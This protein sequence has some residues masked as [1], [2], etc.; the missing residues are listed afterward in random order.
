[1]DT[2]DKLKS[3]LNFSGVSSSIQDNLNSIDT[4]ALAKG[5]SSVSKGFSTLEIMAIAAIAN[6]TSRVVDLGIQMAKSLS[7]DQIA[8]G[9]GQFKEYAVSEATL[10]A[11]GIDQ[12]DVTQT[13]E[14]STLVC[15]RN[16]I[17][18]C[19]YVKQHV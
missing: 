3:S 12:A 7:T 11:Q 8:A 1:M 5:L 19:R 9:W 2:I 13:L 18:I 14:Q 4:S 17:F 6:I 10:L 15:R 16:I